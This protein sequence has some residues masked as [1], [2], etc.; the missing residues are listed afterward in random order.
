MTLL[1]DVAEADGNV[2]ILSHLNADP[3]A[4]GSSIAVYEFLKSKGAEPRLCAAGGVNALARNLLKKLGYKIEI[5]PDLDKTD[6]LFIL[7]TSS[8]SQLSPT[9]VRGFEGR[10]FI[11]DHHLPDKELKARVEKGMFDESMTSTS[12]M[13]FKLLKEEKFDCTKDMC[14]ALITGIVTDTAHL[15]FAR[16]ETFK[17]IA[18]LLELSG[19]TYPEVLNFISIPTEPS[20]KIAHLKSASR[21]RMEKLNGWIVALSS[22][23]SFEASAA[24]ALVK[25]GADV[26]LVCSVVKGEARVSVRASNNFVKKTGLNFARDYADDLSESLD[27]TGGGH[28]AAISVN[29]EFDGNERELLELCFNLLLAKLRQK[30]N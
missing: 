18:D 14:L 30:E 23:S 1:R 11:V 29:G 5:N 19:E 17:I 21:L 10:L 4:I 8:F 24:R 3:D 28:A 20:R 2:V 16:P 9:D 7:D 22:V 25:I 6:T 12:E 13:V 15:Q 27:G 26:G